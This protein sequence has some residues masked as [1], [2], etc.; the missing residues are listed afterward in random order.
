MFPSKLTCP[1]VVCK[2]GNPSHSNGQR[3]S[4][5]SPPPLMKEMKR[6]RVTFSHSLVT[7]FVGFGRFLWLSPRS[8]SFRYATMGNTV[9]KG[10]TYLLLVCSRTCSTLSTLLTAALLV[11]TPVVSS[12]AGSPAAL[13]VPDR[14]CLPGEE[15]YV[16]AILYR[17][18]LLGFLETGVQGELLHFF[19]PEGNPLRDL[20]TDAT[21]LARV[22]YKTGSPG[23]YPIT[24]HLA[25]NPRYSATPSTGNLFVREAGLP[26][27]FVTVED[28]LMPQQFGGF[29]Q[30]NPQEVRPRSGSVKTLSQIAP[31]HVLIYLTWWPKPSS[32]QIR[33]WLETEGYP[34][35][36]IYFL[37]RPSIGA[38]VGAVS[39]PETEVLESL[40]EERSAPAHLA[41]GESNLAMAA[42]EKEIRVFLLGSGKETPPSANLEDDEEEGKTGEKSAKNVT[43]VQEWAEIPTLCRCEKGRPDS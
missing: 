17:S 24:V 12:R 35:G 13:V 38:I 15:I 41:T 29:L 2:H 36:P 28:G 26:L 31:C 30:K 9:H 33:L 1:L 22:R 10:S 19:D 23:R 27:F 34:P 37:D 21:G 43:F 40:R 3:A 6:V 5:R 32:H 7:V 20:L 18:G 39:A 11:L 16:E 25:E 8:S 4:R 14:L 42:A